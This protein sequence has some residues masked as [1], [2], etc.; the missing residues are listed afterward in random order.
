MQMEAV[1]AIIHR[2]LRRVLTCEACGAALV[3]IFILH[4]LF[5]Q[6]LWGTR[7]LLESAQ[8]AP[9]I[10]L[11]GSWTGS[12]VQESLHKVVDP[13]AGAWFS[14]PEFG[15]LH[16]QYF[17][18]KTLPLWN[19]YQGYGQPLAANMQSQPFYPVTLALIVH[20]T[21]KTYN[22]YILIRLFI[23]GIFSYLYLRLFVSF[24]AALAGGVTT[25]LTGYYMLFL[26]LPHLS[27]DVLL[28]A[29]LVAAEYLLRRRTYKTLIAFAVFILLVFLGGMPESA[30]LLFVFVYCYLLFRLLWDRE[31]RTDW[32]SHILRLL[33]A[34]AV[35]IA[36]SAFFLLPFLEFLRHSTNSHDPAHTGYL[37]GLI[38]DVPNLS[39]VTY[40]FPLLFEDAI[41]NVA[42]QVHSATRAYFGLISFAL[43]VIAS[44]R[45][46]RRTADRDRTLNAITGFFLLCVLLT[47]LKRYGLLINSIGALPLF[48]MLDFPKYSSAEL[49]ISASMLSAIGL[50]RLIR[51]D[52][53]R[54]EQCVA[55]G[56]CLSA[57]AFIWVQA[58]HIVSSEL[59]G[60]RRQSKHGADD[61][62]ASRLPVC[63]LG[64]MGRRVRAQ[65][66]VFA[67]E[68]A[69]RRNGNFRYDSGWR[70]SYRLFTSFRS[71]IFTLHY[72]IHRKTHTAARLLW[73][74]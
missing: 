18:E 31:L 49:S 63:V 61:N 36:L 68:M 48:R 4:A 67:S 17:Q 10:F 42:A 54:R 71:L 72:R 39:I 64:V 5:W 65:Q 43:I 12:R 55:L 9:S 32:R 69:E 27:V 34:S 19:P 1:P 73:I 57:L 40:L 41:G 21:P 51:R 38:H 20:L 50:E 29:G 7:T 33:L 8:D 6:C 44:V 26:T 47:L 28:P 52:F 35:G 23:A 11:Q 70:P 56:I 53:N 16:N 59:A 45:M 14:E 30:F 13:G 3:L 25:M 15:L 24:F 66:T 22:W 2:S 62:R 60:W 58:R 37:L 74:F 46:W